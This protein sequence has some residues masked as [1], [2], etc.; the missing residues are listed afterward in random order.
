MH[1]QITTPTLASDNQIKAGPYLHL[2]EE[3]IVPRTAQSSRSKFTVTAHLGGIV[4][5]GG[6]AALSV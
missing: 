6:T 1:W 2:P 3:R 5:S 4:L